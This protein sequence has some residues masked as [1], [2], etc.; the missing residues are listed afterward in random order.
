MAGKEAL[1]T[2]ANGEGGGAN[3]YEK[4]DA[5]SS[6]LILVPC[7]YCFAKITFLVYGSIHDYHMRLP[8]CCR[9]FFGQTNIKIQLL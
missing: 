3:S 4:E 2:P 9:F 8:H 6:V 5:R 1:P 7:L